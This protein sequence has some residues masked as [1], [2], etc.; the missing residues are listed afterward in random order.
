MLVTLDIP[1]YVYNVVVYIHTY[2]ICQYTHGCY[3][4]IN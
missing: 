1:M 3:S 4:K 2:V